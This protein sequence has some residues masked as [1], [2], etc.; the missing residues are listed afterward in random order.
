MNT[1]Q[2]REH[3]FYD[4]NATKVVDELDVRIHDIM[5]KIND[6]HKLLQSVEFDSLAINDAKELLG[7]AYFDNLS[8]IK[9][10]LEMARDVTTQ[11]DKLMEI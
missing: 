2:I 4:F 10:S 5:D 1:T 7:K 8:N 6:A 3:I 11:A 9:I